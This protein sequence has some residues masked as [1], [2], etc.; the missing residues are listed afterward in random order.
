MLSIGLASHLGSV[1][2]LL[3]VLPI[4]VIGYSAATPS[5][6]SLLSLTSGA[7]EQGELLGIGQSMSSMARI[8]GPVVGMILLKLG[9]ALPYWLAAVLMLIG[10]F[11]VLGLR[12]SIPDKSKSD[13][14]VEPT[15]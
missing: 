2:L 3:G 14:T 4:V 11:M 9:I 13:L 5:L 15:T 8:L 7:D 1:N 6:L 10:V 12:N